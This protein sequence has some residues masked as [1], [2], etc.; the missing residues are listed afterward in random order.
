MEPETTRRP[1]SFW[2]LATTDTGILV[3]LGFVKFLVHAMTNI[4][5]GYGYF[6]D[7]LY[8][9]ACTDHMAWGYVDQ[10]P[11]SMAVLWVSRLLFGDSIFA[12][13]LLPAVAG[14]VVVVLAGLMTRELGGKIFAQVLAACSILAAPLLLWAYSVFSMNAFD[15]LFWTLALY[16]IILLMKRDE[17]KYWYLLGVVF[18]LGLLNKISVLWLG[19]GFA[20]GLLLTP[21]RRQFLRPGVWISAS[22]AVILASPHLFWQIAHGFPTL[23]FIRNASLY[24]YASVSP[25]GLFLDQSLTMN[26][27]TILYWVSGVAYFLFAKSTKQFR[28]L[29]LIYL[30]V[31]LILS[32]NRTSKAEY[33]APLF[34]MLFA[35]GAVSV[36]TFVL[37]YRWAWLKP[38]AVTLL[39]L[40]GAITAPLTIAVLPVETF[41]AYTRLLGMKPSS[42]EKKELNALPQHFAD[43]F[44]WERMVA[45]M[46]DAYGTLTPEEKATC[47]LYGN[48]YGE[49]GAIDFFGARY[50]LPKAISGHNS[51][52]MWGP[53]N[54]TGEVVIRLGGTMDALKESYG[55]VLEAG[56]FTDEYCMPYENNQT[57]WICKNRRTP[58]SY[59]WVEFKHFE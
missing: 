49:A 2:S 57:V 37:R 38:V 48:N 15:V 11:L 28:I 18:G 7:E 20:V 52:W 44:G 23:E 45:A 22:L 42:V 8:Y 35:V 32:I 34:P 55:T 6:R 59:E 17:K 19:T 41:I 40:S 53:R 47:T 10:P 29:P 58:L 16:L 27:G 26:P 1:L 14:G 4:F 25:V 5:G 31:F 39:V 33:L 9:I 30:T 24:K 43:M 56:T 21:G 13:R 36:E 12:L 46:A 50:N 54:A 3:T 51:Y